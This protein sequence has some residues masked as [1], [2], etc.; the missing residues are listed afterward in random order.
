MRN[1]FSA[2]LSRD[3]RHQSLK[4][5]DRQFNFTLIQLFRQL[6]LTQ[7]CLNNRPSAQT[8]GLLHDLLPNVG[9][10]GKNPG[11]GIRSHQELRTTPCLERSK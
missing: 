3:L 10:A 5:R 2:L 9:S 6:H 11:S 4:H 7:S 8:T 1:Q